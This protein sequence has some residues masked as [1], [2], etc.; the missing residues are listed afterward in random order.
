MKIEGYVWEVHIL[1]LEFIMG[2]VPAG[3]DFTFV[4]I[5]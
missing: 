3:I 1:T 4:K 2:S 5:W